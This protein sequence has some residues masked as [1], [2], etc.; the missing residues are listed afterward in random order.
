MQ[1]RMKLIVND[2]NIVNM[3]KFFKDQY[4]L[5]DS[6]TGEYIRI[7]DDLTAEDGG[8]SSGQTHDAL[9]ELQ[10]QVV[11]TSDVKNSSAKKAG[12][13]CQTTCNNFINELDKADKDLY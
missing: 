10:K 6:Y 13:N 1:N 12:E 9:V 8:I 2:E 11:T 7:L 4:K 3:G 5:V